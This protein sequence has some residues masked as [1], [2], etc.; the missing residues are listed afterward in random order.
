MYRTKQ[1]IDGL[2]KPIQLHNN[3]FKNVHGY[4]IYTI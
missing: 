4:Y 3:I 1:N 2:L